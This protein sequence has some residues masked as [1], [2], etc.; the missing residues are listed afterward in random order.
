MLVN[1]YPPNY[2]LWQSPFTNWHWFILGRPE[3]FKNIGQQDGLDRS[4]SSF[5]D[6]FHIFHETCYKTWT[7]TCLNLLKIWSREFLFYNYPVEKPG[8]WG[9]LRL[10]RQGFV[11]LGIKTLRSMARKGPLAVHWK[12]TMASN[13]SLSVCWFLRITA[14]CTDLSKN[15]VWWVNTSG[16]ILETITASACR[17]RSHSSGQLHHT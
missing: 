5:N 9:F 2:G 7:W 15:R 17:C 16:S 8:S 1:R 13:C 3:N 4:C 11:F 12:S 10:R 14:H 6:P